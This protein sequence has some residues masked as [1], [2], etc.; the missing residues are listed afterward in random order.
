MPL[1]KSASK[2]AVGKNI[3]AEM[4]AGKPKKQSLAIALSVQDTNKKKKKKMAD[5][6]FVQDVKGDEASGLAYAKK[7]GMGKKNAEGQVKAPSGER[8]MRSPGPIPNASIKPLKTSINGQVV[9]KFNKDGEYNDN[10]FIKDP[11]AD[12]EGRDNSKGQHFADGGMVDNGF[13]LDSEFSENDKEN[14]MQEDRL[15]MKMNK[16]GADNAEGDGGQMPG[17]PADM[18]GPEEQMASGYDKRVSNKMGRDNAASQMRMAKG[19][20][21]DSGSMDLDDAAEDDDVS[22]AVMRKRYADGGQVDQSNVDKGLQSIRKAFGGDQPSPQ[23]PQPV[24]K[25]Y[26]GEIMKE[27]YDDEE[28]HSSE[29]EEDED[30]SDSIMR[31]RY[32]DGGMVDL[33]EESEEQPNEYDDLNEDA[34]DMPQYDDDQLSD[35][36]M[37]SNEHGDEYDDRDKSDQYDMIEKMRQ[38]IKMRRGY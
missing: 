32:A 17:S 35:Q 15:K 36:P 23:Q 31:K 7:D 8:P 12:K 37:D 27:L 20:M 14:M 10:W 22:D 21:V 38:R 24:N 5:G 18:D 4:S 1:I 16:R 11:M 26:G 25:A 34:A 2:K 29:R 9:A 19:G 6:G 33:E 28:D 30:L 13:D 3:E